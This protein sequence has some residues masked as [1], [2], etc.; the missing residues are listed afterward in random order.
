MC[1]SVHLSIHLSIHPSIQLS[2]HPSNKIAWKDLR[3]NINSTYFCVEYFL[4]SIKFFTM[5]VDYW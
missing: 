3:Q 5:D 2:I 4:M 1:L